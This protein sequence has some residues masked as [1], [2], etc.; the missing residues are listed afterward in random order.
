MAQKLWKLFKA[1][2]FEADEEELLDPWYLPIFISIEHARIHALSKKFKMSVFEIFQHAYKY[3][4]STMTSEHEDTH[5][6][7]EAFKAFTRGTP[8]PPWLVQAL[9]NSPA[10]NITA[11]SLEEKIRSTLHLT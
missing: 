2:F 8:L 10:R 1:I 6:V 5:A 4:F 11:T 3:H 9:R 7:K